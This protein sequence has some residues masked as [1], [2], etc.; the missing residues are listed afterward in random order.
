[1]SVTLIRGIGEL[2]TME[3][4]WKKSGRH[5]Q[6]EDLG[7]IKSAAMLVDQGLIQWVGL[8]KHLSKALKDYLAT[9]ND[10]TTRNKKQNAKTKKIKRQNIQEYDVCGQTVLPGWIDAHTHTVFAGQRWSEFEMRCQGASYQ[11]IAAKGGGILSTMK[12][13]RSISKKHLLELSQARVNEFMRQGVSTLEVKSGYA[14]EKKGE[15]KQLEVARQ[16][17]G[18]RIVTTFLGAHAKPPEFSSADEYLNFLSLEVL[19]VI[20]KRK[21]ASRVDIF[22]EKNFFE[23]KSAKQYLEQ[24]KSLGFDITVHADQLSLSGGTRLAVELGALSADHVIQLGEA[25]IKQISQSQAT[26]VLLPMAD[27]YMKCAYPPARALIDQGARV[28]L[29]TDFNPGSCPS[30]DVQLVGLLAR[31]EMKMSLPEII[32]AW[33]IGGARA[34]GF[35]NVGA[36]QK[37]FSADF[38][39]LDQ[40][41]RGLF[42]QAGR[43]PV[44]KLFTTGNSVWSQIEC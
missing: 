6:S 32:S 41:W 8:E 11:E 25:E 31:L 30:Q 17:V 24:A 5:I 33:T 42:Y 2:L 26:A 38:Q 19:P 1:M 44:T 27:L 16:L 28:A 3:G 36:L 18:P 20:K 22:V 12:A 37:D 15:L 34:L 21:L 35:D 7:G 23:S 14:L 13:T 4:A 29:A 40:D 10:K 9:S 39:V 43:S